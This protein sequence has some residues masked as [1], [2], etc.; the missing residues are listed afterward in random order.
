MN[1]L[2]TYIAATK[3]ELNGVKLEASESFDKSYT[4]QGIVVNC[5]ES[6]FHFNNGVVMKCCNEADML[7]ENE[8][9]CAECWISYEVISESDD[10]HICPQR[11][12]FLNHCQE[13]FW[14]KINTQQ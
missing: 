7:E 13:A 11:K 8:Q 12:T 10:T 6:V 2:H 5:I 3:G 1:N 9:I 4:D 14:L